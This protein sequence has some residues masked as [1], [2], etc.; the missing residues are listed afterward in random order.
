MSKRAFLIVAGAFLG[1]V[2]AAWPAVAQIGRLQILRP[3]PASSAS[4]SVAVRWTDELPPLIE[5]EP[6]TLT[7]YYA[8]R[9]DA[10]DRQRLTTEFYENF[11]RG[12]RQNWRA[13]GPFAFDW[14]VRED[15]RLKINY[16]RGQQESGPMVSVVPIEGPVVVS[17]RVRPRGDRS[18]FVIGARVQEDGKGYQ[19]RSFGNRLRIMAPGSPQP[20]CQEHVPSLSPD[21]WYWIEMGLRT[22]KAQEV[23]IRV[24]VFDEKREQLLASFGAEDRP[25]RPQ[26]RGLLQSG[27]LSLWGRADFAELYVDPWSARWMHDRRNEF[28]WNTTAVPDGQYYL[29]AEVAGEKDRPELVISDFQVDVRNPSRAARD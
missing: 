1:G 25:Q 5:G 21:K 27:K 17:A 9:R 10:G 3:T 16:L 11:E 2:M 29:V 13:E 15:D 12:F 4:G 18:N 22:R 6:P 26:D 20:L 23:E 14:K 24:R 8:R 28:R 7:W 19:L